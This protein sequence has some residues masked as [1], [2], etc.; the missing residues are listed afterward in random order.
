M[1]MPEYR[2]VAIQWALSGTFLAVVRSRFDGERGPLS[3]GLAASLLGQMVVGPWL[4]RLA[5]LVLVLLAQLFK[6]RNLRGALLRV[7]GFGLGQAAGRLIGAFTGLFFLGLEG[8]AMGAAVGEALM[9]TLGY[10]FA[11]DAG[12][13]LAS[14][15]KKTSPVGQKGGDQTL[16]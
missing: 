4:S 6:H 5:S 2:H 7:W 11:G 13:R 3:L 9:A 8:G 14:A 15:T 12:D 16:P 1:T 10:Q